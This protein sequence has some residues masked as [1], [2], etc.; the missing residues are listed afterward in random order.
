MEF[1]IAATDK[2]IMMVEGESAEAQEEDLIKAIEIAHEAIKMQ[3]KAQENLRDAV[4]ITGKRE[5]T[6]PYRNE[7]LKEK[8]YSYGKEY[9]ISLAYSN[10]TICLAGELSSFQCNH[11]ATTNIK[12]Y[13]F[14]L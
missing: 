2:N 6:K 14:S 8:I 12:G 10:R 4:G 11:T 3:V 13:W 9:T 5:Y 1:L 7:E